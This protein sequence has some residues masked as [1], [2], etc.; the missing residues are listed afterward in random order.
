MFRV[1]VN[2][3]RD[4]HRRRVDEVELPGEGHPHEPTAPAE[5][6]AHAERRLDLGRALSKLRARDR[7]MLWLAYAE[8]ASH[9][10][11]ASAM[12]L[13]PASIKLL[14]FRARRRLASLLRPSPADGRAR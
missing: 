5:S 1:A 4:R 3:V 6:P 7:D 14:L 12:G 11:I 10:E 13:R 2:L 9:E 8:G